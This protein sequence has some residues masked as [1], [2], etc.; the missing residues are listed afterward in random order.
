MDTSQNSFAMIPRG[1][2]MRDRFVAAP[3]TMPGWL[4]DAD[5]DVYVGEFERSGLTGGF[6]RY[7]N[8]QRDWEDLAFV[9]GMPITVPS[10]FIGGSKDGPT[11]WGKRAIDRFPTTLPGLTRSVDPRRLRPLD[12]AGAARRR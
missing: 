3:D 7:R 1:G 8:V 2:R 4:S 6:N 9:A 11:L 12:P 10:L 5:L